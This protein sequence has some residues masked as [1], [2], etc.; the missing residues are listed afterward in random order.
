MP[1]QL[2]EKH[3]MSSDPPVD[4]SKSDYLS[5]HRPLSNTQMD[6]PSRF[7]RKKSTNNSNASETTAKI[8]KTTTQ[9]DNELQ[10]M[11]DDLI[12]LIGGWEQ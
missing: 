7:I 8:S 2:Q 5:P 6:P 1:T 10:F 9:D 11:M 12:D 3:T 4:T